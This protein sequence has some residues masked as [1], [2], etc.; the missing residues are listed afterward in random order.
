V[1]KGVVSQ[2]MKWTRDS[3]GVE[4]LKREPA[5][6]APRLSEEQ[7]TKVPELLACGAEAHGLGE[8]VAVES[9]GEKHMAAEDNKAVVRRFY[10]EV[11][12]GG[13]LDLVDQLFAP[14]WVLYEDKELGFCEM[15]DPRGPAAVRAV[16]QR[17]RRYYSDLQVSIKDQIAAEGAHVVT[18]FA[19]SGTRLD[20]SVNVK[21]I[22]ISQFSAGGQIAGTWMNVESG[23]LYFQLG[24]LVEGPD[25][26]RPP[27]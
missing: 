26:R 22:S 12:E 1:R 19:F 20:R 9:R 14:E 8:R 4:A 23:L 5:P 11:L 6:G 2:W 16:V 18:R 13:N 7:R 25:W 21:G 15:P 17:I 3:G 24:Y 10:K 27:H